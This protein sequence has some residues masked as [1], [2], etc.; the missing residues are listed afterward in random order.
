MPLF[1]AIFDRDTDRLKRLLQRRANPNAVEC[2]ETPLTYALSRRQEKI[3]EI[4][5]AH[6]ADI[7]APVW[8]GRDALM[9]S[10]TAKTVEFL[11]QHGASVNRTDKTGSTALM[12]A[13]ES[14]DNSCLRLLLKA[15]ADIN[16]KDL[17]GRTALR[18]ANLAARAA[19]AH[20]LEQAGG[21]E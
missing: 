12:Y 1:R 5:L 20:F 2:W 9:R 16:A 21:V 19:M 8:Q 18:R 15:G 4:L 6:G 10:G 11:L 17:A 13:A 14:A 3:A 7:H